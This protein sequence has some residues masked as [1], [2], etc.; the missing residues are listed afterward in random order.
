MLLD[1]DLGRMRVAAS[2]AARLMSPRSHSPH[3]CDTTR[4]PVSGALSDP[5]G[6]R[7]SYDLPAAATSETTQM[8]QKVSQSKPLPATPP[9]LQPR[10]DAAA[11]LLS[12]LVV[13]LPQRRLLFR[14]LLLL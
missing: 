11:G 8:S 9:S 13:G 3:E 5:G 14:L 2:A 6:L 7:D 1:V 4:S 10:H 12:R